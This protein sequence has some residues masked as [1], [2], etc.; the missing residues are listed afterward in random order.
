VAAAIEQNHDD[1]G[2]IWPEPMAPFQVAILPVNGHK[3]H[4]AREQ[5][6]KFY[7]ELTAAGIEVLM[8]DRPLRPGVMFADAELIGIPHQLVIGDRGLD[9]GIVEYRQRGVDSMDVE[10]DRVFGFMQEKR[11]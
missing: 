2:I 8:D 3:S 7:E 5:A 9:K 11:S 6:E 4:R 1:A 10:I